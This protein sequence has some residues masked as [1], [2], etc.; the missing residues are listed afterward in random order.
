MA[1]QALRKSSSAL[2]A[3]HR[4]LCARMDRPKTTTAT[5]HKRARLVCLMPT[6]G[7]A[8]TSTDADAGQ[9]YGEDRDRE[10]VVKSL[11]KRAPTLCFHR[12]PAV[13]PA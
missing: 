6:K 5:A 3:Y 1:A 2:G 10:R 4:K 8:Y 12:V 7:Q 13:A 11:T 9:Q